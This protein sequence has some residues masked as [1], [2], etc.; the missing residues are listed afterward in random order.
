ME[1]K[2]ELSIEEKQNEINPNNIKTKSSKIPKNEF[3]EETI[4]NTN[5]GFISDGNISNGKENNKIKEE[6]GYTFNI[7]GFQ[8]NSIAYFNEI[9]LD[10]IKSDKSNCF[11][12]KFDFKTGDIF[13]INKSILNM[14]INSD[15]DLQGNIDGIITDVETETI[16]KAKK[17][18]SFN[19]FTKD[20]FLKS[21]KTYDIF[22]ASTFG[23]IDNLANQNSN[24]NK[25]LIQLKKL[26]SII[27]LIQKINNEINIH[28]EQNQKDLK[29]KIN[30]L[31]HHKE[32]NNIILCFIFDRN[33]KK[34]MKQMKNSFLF[35]KEKKIWKYPDENGIMKIL[36]DYF[37]I[38]IESKIPFLIVYCPRVYERTSKYYNPLSKKYIEDNDIEQKNNSFNFKNENP[39]FKKKTQKLNE[40]LEKQK[41]IMQELDNKLKEH[42]IR[43]TNLEEKINILE[44]NYL[45]GKKRIRLRF[46][47]KKNIKRK[48]NNRK[49]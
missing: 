16:E 2:E 13:K 49:K 43:L 32:S 36:Y 38:L 41:E 44:K 15:F 14:A 48:K 11:K 30:E 23:L 5:Q 25:K 21:G 18:N 19:I 37:D 29:L 28:S 1:Q 10:N 20:N 42:D 46:K 24:D 47:T 39:C 31:F 9:L 12:I 8:S 33:Y 45:L 4:V 3:M 7:D 40:K 26:I 27:K 22:C 6:Y 17:N 35:S 34:L